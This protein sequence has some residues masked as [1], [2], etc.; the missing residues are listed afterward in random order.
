MGTLAGQA[1]VLEI[2]RVSR[3]LSIF[4][5][6][7]Y[8]RYWC[9]ANRRSVVLQAVTKRRVG[10]VLRKMIFSSI[11]EAWPSFSVPLSVGSGHG[12]VP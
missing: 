1:D 4:E 5:V 3:K 7:T 10:T 9:S 2:A 11:V 6:P 12:L 8:C